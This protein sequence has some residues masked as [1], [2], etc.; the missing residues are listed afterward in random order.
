M[1]FDPNPSLHIASR[2]LAF[3]IMSCHPISPAVIVIKD[4]DPLPFSWNPFLCNFPVAWNIFRWGRTP[5]G[6]WRR[7]VGNRRW[8]SISM[9]LMG[10]QAS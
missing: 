6:F 5:P 10:Y 2:G 9:N 3:F 4:P 8:R 7:I 1:A